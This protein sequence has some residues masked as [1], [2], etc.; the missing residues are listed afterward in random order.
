MF[1]MARAR[2]SR[3]ASFAK[4]MQ[5]SGRRFEGLWGFRGLG[6]RIQNFDVQ[7]SCCG[8]LDLLRLLGSDRGSSGRG[9]RVH[10]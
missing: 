6:V 5:L 9:C 10:Q 7:D 4:K 1:A 8:L 2:A 3:F